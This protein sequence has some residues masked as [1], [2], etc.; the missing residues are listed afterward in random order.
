MASLISLLCLLDMRGGRY[1]TSRT[2]INSLVMVNQWIESKKID[3]FIRK[4]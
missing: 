3:G 4:M 2:K 1:R